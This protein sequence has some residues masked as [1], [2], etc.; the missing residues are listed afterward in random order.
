MDSK[1]IIKYIII[2]MISIALVVLITTYIFNNTGKINQGSFRINDA[3]IT[4]SLNIEEKQEEKVES[5]SNMVL[6]IDE[7]NEIELM[8]AKNAN[9]TNAT[10]SDFKINNPVKLGKITLSQDKYN[11]KYEV[12]KNTDVNI[13][14]EKK[15]DQCYIS[16]NIDNEKC[17]SDVNVPDQTNVVK[18]DGTILELLNQKVDDLKFDV[19]FNLNIFDDLGNKNTCK[20]KLK[21]P[22][23]KIITE[24]ISITRDDLTKY[25]FVEKKNVTAQ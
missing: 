12:D 24:G 20:I 19:S 21:V 23:D 7:E 8:I 22:D 15:D 18:F 2:V 6:D 5:L 14:T 13:Y 1:K 17:M 16:L 3:V 25:V 10:V 11:L 4:S 9:I